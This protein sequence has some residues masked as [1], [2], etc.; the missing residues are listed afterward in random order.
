MAPAAS[1]RDGTRHP[2]SLSSTA[3]NITPSVGLIS[4]PRRMPVGASGPMD[5][6]AVILGAP[7]PVPPQEKNWFRVIREK[8]HSLVT[9]KAGLDSGAFHEIRAGCI[10]C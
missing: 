10:T 6:G 3:I 8:M 9:R 1:L 2:S 7:H 4:D 5:K